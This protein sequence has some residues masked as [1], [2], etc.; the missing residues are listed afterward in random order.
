MS[1]TYSASIV[2]VK[3]WSSPSVASTGCESGNA[4]LVQERERVVAH[5]DDQLRLHDPQL[6]REPRPRLVLVAAGELEA[7][8]A[9]D[10]ER[11]DAEPLERLD[12]RVP[13]AA[14]EGDALLQ[15]LRLRPVLEQEDRRQRMA[16]RLRTGAARGRLRDLVLEA[17]ISVIALSRYR[18]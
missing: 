12:Q 1:G 18:L 6:A 5:H 16:A 8:R 7:V 15:L 4:E 2:G 9:E 17:R 11:V 13:G 3:R 10:L 14:V